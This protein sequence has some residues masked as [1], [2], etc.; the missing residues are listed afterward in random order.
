MGKLDFPTVDFLR[1]I[2][3]QNWLLRS[4]IWNLKKLAFLYVGSS[5][6]NVINYSLICFYISKRPHAEI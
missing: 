3:D 6:A 4:S 5:Q 2:F 1:T